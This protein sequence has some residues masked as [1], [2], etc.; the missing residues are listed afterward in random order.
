MNIV[1]IGANR[2]NDDLTPIIIEN[3]QRLGKVILIEPLSVHHNALKECYKDIPVIIEGLVITDDKN[4]HELSF[5]LSHTDAPNYELSTL[6]K[7]HL[8]KHAVKAEDI[9]E[10]KVACTTLNALLEKH[11]LK[12]IDILFIDAE[13]F[14]EAI[15]RSINF[16]KYTIHKIV[17]ENLHVQSNDRLIQ[18][19]RLKNYL[20]EAKCGHNGWSNSAIKQHRD[21]QFLFLK[22]I[23]LVNFWWQNHQKNILQ[24]LKKILYKMGLF[25]IMKSLKIFLLDARNKRVN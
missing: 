17:Y 12:T 10:E 7:E 9:V 24:K 18:F 14:D 16:S 22:P 1:Q 8:L 25:K 15:I 20:I 19:L 23:L 13:G 11:Q 4:L 2:G 21:I 6:S 5:Y 3:K